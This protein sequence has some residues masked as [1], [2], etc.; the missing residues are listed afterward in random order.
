MSSSAVRLWALLLD[1]RIGAAADDDGD[2]VSSV[3]VPSYRWPA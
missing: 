1:Q 2:A 3:Q